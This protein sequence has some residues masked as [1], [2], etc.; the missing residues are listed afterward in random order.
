MPSRNLRRNMK[1]QL[2]IKYLVIFLLLFSG[3]E[4]NCG[5]KEA[6]KFAREGIDRAVEIAPRVKKRKSFD[7]RNYYPNKIEIFYKVSVRRDSTEEIHIKST[8]YSDVDK[9][10]IEVRLSKIDIV[11]SLEDALL[12]A[13]GMVMKKGFIKSG[14]KTEK[15]ETRISDFMVEI[16]VKFEG[17]EQAQIRFAKIKIKV[18]TS[19][20]ESEIGI[21]EAIRRYSIPDESFI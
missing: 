2:R 20:E 11:K 17:A 12:T 9:A 21:I 7:S 18:S 15:I 4:V 1:R 8:G 19:E 13:W 10:T 16:S 3:L 14:K 6:L 5:V